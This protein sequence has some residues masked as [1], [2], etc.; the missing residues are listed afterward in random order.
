MKRA[1][2]SPGGSVP[3]VLAKK[4][5]FAD[6]DIVVNVMAIAVDV[7]GTAYTFPGGTRLRAGHP[8]VRAS[9]WAWE[10]ADVLT[11]GSPPLLLGVP[12]SHVPETAGEEDLEHEA[13]HVPDRAA[14]S[15][16]EDGGGG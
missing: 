2:S 14:G 4:S 6:K 3:R 15:R 10:R 7:A 13:P 5:R 11:E 1:P 9:E 8:A 12:V 16:H